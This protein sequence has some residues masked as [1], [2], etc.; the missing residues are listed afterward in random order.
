[1]HEA[2]DK[3][4][5]DHTSNASERFR[6]I[7]LLEYTSFEDL[8]KIPFDMFRRHHMTFRLDQLR[9]ADKRRQFLQMLIPFVQQSDSW[10]AC[11]SAA[12]GVSK[13]PSEDNR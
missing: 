5:W 4:F 10:K 11:I 6:L 13:Q 8:L 2:L 9:T 7:R 1:M 3:Y 12:L